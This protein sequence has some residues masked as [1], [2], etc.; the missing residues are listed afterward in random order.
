M[1][2]NCPVFTASLL[3]YA[4]I[5]C[6]FNLIC[7]VS[8]QNAKNK[9]QKNIQFTTKLRLFLMAYIVLTADVPLGN[10]SLTHNF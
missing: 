6:W 10:Y 3:W 5:V 7:T 9:M 8:K 1:L 2:I 4:N